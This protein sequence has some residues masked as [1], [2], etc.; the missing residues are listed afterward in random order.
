MGW[1]VPL[2]F[3]A[4]GDRYPRRRYGWK[5]RDGG[6]SE[7]A[8]A[9]GHAQP[10]RVPGCPWLCFT[11]SYETFL[12]LFFGTK[13]VHITLSST[14]TRTERT[15]DNTDDLIAKI[16][17]ARVYGGMHYRSSVEDGVVV[18]GKAWPSG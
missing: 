6:R 12:R 7:L 1:Q 3:L 5:R 18:S 11:G 10:S 15:F 2:Q 4:S 8:A 13:K 14:V 17:N 16:I 9:G